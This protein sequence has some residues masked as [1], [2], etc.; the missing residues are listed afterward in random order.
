MAVPTNPENLPTCSVY[1]EPSTGTLWF[2][3][4][5]EHLWFNIVTG[6]SGVLS[7]NGRAGVVVP[8]VGDYS[9]FYYAI[10]T[11][12]TAQYIRGDGTLATFPSLTG[13]VP[14]AGATSNVNLGTFRLIT[15]GVALGNGTTSITSTDPVTQTDLVGFALKVASDTINL[16]YKPGVYGSLRLGVLGSDATPQTIAYLTDIPDI[17]GFVPYVGAESDVDLDTFSLNAHNL[18][19]TD[20]ST[21]FT[22]STDDQ[23]FV[24][25]DGDGNTATIG[26]G[27]FNVNTGN[28][29][30]NIDD[31]G[32]IH[33]QRSDSS[34]DFQVTGSILS[35]N[36]GDAVG[37]FGMTASNF[38]VD[39]DNA[40]IKLNTST[41]FRLVLQDGTS[42]LSLTADQLKDLAGVN[43]LKATAL[44][45][46][47]LD[48]T[49]V[50]RTGSLA[51]IV[52]GVKTFSSQPIFS[53]G[54]YSGPASST[55]NVGVAGNVGFINPGGT[56]GTAIVPQ[57]IIAYGSAQNETAYL[58]ATS[59]A[60]NNNLSFGGAQQFIQPT[61]GTLSVDQHFLLPNK[62]GGGT[63]AL[64]SDLALYLPLT[65]GTLTGSLTIAGTAGAGYIN[66]LGQ[67]SPP[68]TPASST[69]NIYADA[70]G[71]FTIMGSN[72]FY[73]SF[74]K[75]LLTASRIYNLPDA[76]GTFVLA[77]GTS[78]QYIA[79]DGTY[80][81]FPTNVSSFSN[82][83]GYLTN[84]T[85]DARF[86]KLSGSISTG[87]QIIQAAITTQLQLGYDSS[88]YLQ[89]SIASTGSATFGLT[90]TTPTFT[91]NQGILSNAAATAVAFSSSAT[92][93]SSNLL[94]LSMGSAGTT[95]ATLQLGGATT[96]NYRISMRGSS[97]ASPAANSSY[98]GTIIGTQ[99]V[100][101]ASSGTHAI[102]AQL[103][104]KP[105]TVTTGSGTVTAAATLLVEGAAPAVTGL[106]AGSTYAI[107]SQAGTNRFTGNILNDALTASQLVATDASKNL[108]SIT[109]LPSGTTATTQAAADNSTKVATTAYVDRTKSGNITLVAGVGT[110]TVTGVSTGS[111]AT[112]GFVS[113]GGTVTTTWQY[114]YAVTANTVTI[115]AI[116]N[117]GATNTLDTSVLTYRVTL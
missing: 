68:A 117:A 3:T 34:L 53:G 32:N 98:G 64:T 95:S 105:A 99:V 47:A 90:G 16:L 39:L 100:N 30:F 116:T 103:A 13:Y 67:S 14:Y 92:T 102:F 29:D 107:Y 113:I 76:A 25:D 41:G 56:Y 7:F 22:L 112:L 4:G 77:N 36:T 12:T 80:V 9:A 66:L 63:F 104:V 52:T 27:L 42:G 46:Y 17:T 35:Y 10:P 59:L 88:N 85:G 109:D 91:F 49:V 15:G 50:H 84:T 1:F 78:A 37:Q 44:S 45:A 57:G 73:A 24:F 61:S 108:V 71:R 21:S 111:L 86:V 65:G 87:L 8:L 40:S 11:G 75:S 114:K 51:E 43:Y 58:T 31:T 5:T 70:S 74:S 72:G 101:I 69:Q 62:V 83:S 54:I 60:F 38:E 89:I 6:A 33:Y 97:S 2:Y 96:T 110:A 79:G 23:T 81:T 106:A 115:T 18:I 20:G 82:D 93:T 28:F 94:A 26:S 55:F 48:S 19:A